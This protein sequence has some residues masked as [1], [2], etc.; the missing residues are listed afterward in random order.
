METESSKPRVLLIAEAA[1]PQWVSVPLEGWSHSRAIAGIAEA[2]VV[3]Q[4]R[5]RDAFIEAGLIEGQ[6]FT[7]IDSQKVAGPLSELA[8]KI[9]GGHGKGW[10]TLMAFNALSYYYFERQLWKRFGADLKAGRFDLVHR[11]TPLSP[12]TPSLLAKKLHR[13]GVPFVLGPLNGGLPWPKGFDQARRRERE[14]LSY[15]RSIY[16]FMPGYR[17]TRKFASAMMIGSRAT[18]EQMSDR[19]SAQCVYVPENA[20]DP[21]RFTRFVDRSISLP[22]KLAFVGRFVPY[23]GADMLLEAA[24]PLIRQGQ[25]TVDLIGEGPMEQSLRELAC[26]LDI[27]AGVKMDG[28]VAHDQLQ[29]RLM[30]SDVFA[31]PSIREFGGAVV[32]EAMAVGLVPVVIDYGGPGELVSAQ[33][34]FA[35]PIGSR[36]QIIAR[37]RKAI[38]QLVASPERLETMR[39]HARQRVFKYF[40]WDAKAKQ[41]LEVYRWVLG[42]RMAKPDFGMP[43]LDLPQESESVRELVGVCR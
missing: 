37:F 36:D 27:V 19:Y 2:H 26:Q 18:F 10:T 30:Q 32:L 4:I 35:I 20:V 24:A 25:V 21:K 43:L 33:T 31:F 22:L 6:D 42:Q 1:N 29:D 41:V 12:T 23:K 38:E 5:N 11:L 3:T 7:A 40:T 28:W 39:H 14:W 8:Y 15:V 13:I 34:G 16:K 9:R 17:A